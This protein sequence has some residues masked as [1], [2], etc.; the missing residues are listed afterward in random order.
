VVT[1]DAGES[2]I[3]G[4]ARKYIEGLKKALGTVRCDKVPGRCGDLLD[5]ARRYTG[6]AEYYLEAGDCETALSA[7]SYAEG[8]LDSLKYL[9]FEE[10]VWPDRSSIGQRLGQ[11]VF[12]AGTFDLLHPGHVRLLR[13]ASRLGKV[14]VVV[15]RDSNVV[16]SKGKRPILSEKA[17]LENVSSLK[18]VYRAML[19]DEKDKL[20]PLRIIEPDI[21]VLGPDQPWDENELSRTA[22]SIL[23]KKVSV[24][25]YPGKEEFEP[26]LKSTT[27]IVR[28]ICQGSYCSVVAQSR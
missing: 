13:F 15:A 19:G 4:R 24:V 1:A 5:A 7:A 27:D 18:Y 9:G 6:D 14:Y 28:R 26:G 8:L 17:R 2:S 23:G 11:R 16:R 12:V 22:S 21:I 25:R 10:P 20:A 3:C